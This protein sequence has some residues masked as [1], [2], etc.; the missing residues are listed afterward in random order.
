MAI[1]TAGLPGA[2]GMEGAPAADREEADAKE[3]S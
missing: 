2:I 3:V 1:L